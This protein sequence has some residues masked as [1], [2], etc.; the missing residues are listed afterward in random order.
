MTVADVVELWTVPSLKFAKDDTERNESLVITS[1][2][3]EVADSEASR[4]VVESPDITTVMTAGGGRKL[5]DVLL[6]RLPDEV[7]RAEK[8]ELMVESS[9]ALLLDPEGDV[10]DEAGA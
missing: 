9:G 2:A 5:P 7:I 8:A 4:V 1:V 3:W 6:L 10:V